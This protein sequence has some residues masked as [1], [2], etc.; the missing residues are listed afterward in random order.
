[1]SDVTQLSVDPTA[2]KLHLLRLQAQVHERTASSDRDSI[3]F[4]YSCA[5]QV[6]EIRGRR[7]ID[8]RFE[9][10]EQ[11][12]PYFYASAR[13]DHA[14]EAACLMRDLGQLS[15]RRDWIRRAHTFIGVIHGEL[16]NVSSA[17]TEYHEALRLAEELGDRRG[18]AGTFLNLG[19]AFLYGG[20]FN[21]A[22]ACFRQTLNISERSAC[23][24]D[25]VAG[26]FANLAQAHFYSG[27]NQEAYD[28]ACRALNPQFMPGTLKEL[29]S[30]TI[31]EL[32]F[33]RIAVMMG[34]IAGG[35]RTCR[36]VQHLRASCRRQPKPDPLKASERPGRVLCG[37]CHHWASHAARMP[38]GCGE[39]RCSGEDRIAGNPRTRL[40]GMPSV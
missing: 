15:A 34:K 33:V 39:L 18:A 7:F 32:T 12:V 24:K 6:S 25:L 40:P 13:L 31:H 11:L 20:L 19:N 26:A 4:V 29:H 28:M 16:G 3:D 27:E 22:K 14:L 8:I 21:D 9:C 23:H 35:G 36:A 38:R 5:R 1:M 37:K 30:K 17:I 10:A 2:L